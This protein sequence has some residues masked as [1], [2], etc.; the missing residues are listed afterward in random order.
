MNKKKGNDDHVKTSNLSVDNFKKVF[1]LDG[2]TPEPVIWSG[3]TGQRIPC[4]YS[5]QLIT[6]LMGNQWA[7][8]VAR[9]VR[10]N[11]GMPV[12]QTDGLSQA[13]GSFQLAEKR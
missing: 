8:K 9:S 7:P 3:D 5:C 10:V 6:T 4:F 2:S 1:D 11:I 13:H 12:V